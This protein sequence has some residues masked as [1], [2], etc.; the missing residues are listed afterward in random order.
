MR[1]WLGLG[2]AGVVG[3]CLLVAACGDDDGDATSTSG[4]GA[5][6]GQG[7]RASGGAG[8]QTGPGSGGGGA[9]SGGGG[10]APVPQNQFLYVANQN[11]DTVSVYVIGEAGA[12]THVEDEAVAGRPGPL[13]VNPGETRFYA[14]SVQ[15]R[16][17]S[18]FDIDAATG[19]LSPIGGAVSVQPA[20]VYIAVDATGGHLL[21]ASYGNNVSQSFAIQGDGAIAGTPTSS[22]NGPGNNPHAIVLSPNNNFAYVP[23]TNPTPETISQFVFNAASGTLTENSAGATVDA[24][25]VEPVGPRHLT[26]HPTLDLLYV[27]NEHSDSVTTY[28]YNAAT[29]VLTAGA[30]VSTLP[31][32]SSDGSNTCADIHITPDGSALYA[33]NRGDN[34]IAMFAVDAA[35]ALTPLGHVATE[36]VPREFEVTRDGRFLYAAGQ[37][38]DRL[39]GYRIESDGSLTA[40]EPATIDV[41][42]RPMW[43]LAI[44]VDQPM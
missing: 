40:L 20:P 26:F 5:G 21:L 22:L 38:T 37:D 10:G 12:L 18:A 7:G 44:S 31:G 19:A 15:G 28:A 41:G 34:S 35:G 8:G 39:A 2:G 24:S 9:G 42:D 14:A 16:S 1:W 36:A 3:A 6:T 17:V 23:N 4:S 43:V 33:S 29:G 13:A 25:G 30:T 27:V 32:G 11:D